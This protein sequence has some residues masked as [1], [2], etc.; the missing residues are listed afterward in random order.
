MSDDYN[1]HVEIG[2]IWDDVL[3]AVTEY[4]EMMATKALN[5][6]CLT[7]IYTGKDVKQLE[8]QAADKIAELEKIDPVKAEEE[9]ERIWRAI[10]EISRGNG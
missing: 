7:M 6:A 5:E 10:Q 2:Y 8:E 3:G 4:Q 9:K 1:Q